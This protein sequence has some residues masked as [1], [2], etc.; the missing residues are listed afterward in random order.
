MWQKETK[1]GDIIDY[2]FEFINGNKPMYGDV[3][4][5]PFEGYTIV[6]KR[7]HSSTHIHLEDREE[8]IDTIKNHIAN[9]DEYVKQDEELAKYLTSDEGAWG[10]QDSFDNSIDWGA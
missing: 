5:G 2:R 10:R 8:A 7:P 6:L 3:K 1:E 4:R 9:Y